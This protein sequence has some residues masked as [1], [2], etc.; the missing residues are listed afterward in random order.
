M[1]PVSAEGSTDLSSHQ[2][3]TLNPTCRA[4]LAPAGFSANRAIDDGLV[5]RLHTLTYC[6]LKIQGN[7]LD[8]KRLP[9]CIFKGMIRETL[10]TGRFAV[11]DRFLLEVAVI[12]RFLDEPSDESFTG[13]YKLF[14]SRLVAF[15]RARSCDPGLS[16]DLAQ[17]VMLTVYRKAGQV[18][19]RALFHA[20]LFRIAHNAL[21]RHYGK[22]A[23]EVETVCVEDSVDRL[24]IVSAEPGAPAFEFMH[25]MGFLNSRER[26]VMTLRFTSKSGNTT[27]LRPPSECRS[28]PSSGSFST[29]RKSWLRD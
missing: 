27:K 23:R 20:W 8:R 22:Q 1:W 3:R 21:C 13:L 4:S 26:E 28:A 9:E 18:R 7:C 17:Q 14:T 12:R 10:V 15:Y 19:D 16:E 25:W 29:Q 24:A 5:I 6:P 11:N 2:I